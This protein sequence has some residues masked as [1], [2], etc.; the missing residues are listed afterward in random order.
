M[1]SRPC[2]ESVLRT[3]ATR[4]PSGEIAGGPETPL[5]SERGSQSE[6]GRAAAQRRLVE[7]DRTE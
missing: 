6:P 1:L 5:I 7:L 4:R 3:K 2:V